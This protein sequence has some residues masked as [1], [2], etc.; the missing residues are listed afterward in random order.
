MEAG[1]KYEKHILDDIRELPP[2][3]LPKVSKLIHFFKNEILIE[4]KNFKSKKVNHFRMLE[5]I[6][7]GKIEHTDE[8]I[9]EA[10]IKLK[11]I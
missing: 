1:S 11:E 4:S 5:G 8:D 6:F 10:K 9:D 3:V 2:S 7:H